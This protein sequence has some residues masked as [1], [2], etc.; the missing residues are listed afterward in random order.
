MLL[1]MQG[2]IA[3]PA[4]DRTTGGKRWSRPTTKPIQRIR[5]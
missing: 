5:A 3:D 4:F 2:G 1:K